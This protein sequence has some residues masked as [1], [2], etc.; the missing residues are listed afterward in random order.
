MIQAVTRNNALSQ[1]WVKCTVHTP[2]AQATH[3]PRALRPSRVHSAVSQLALGRVVART[4]AVSWSCLA[5]SQR[6][7]TMS[8]AHA[9]VSQTPDHDTNFVSQHRPLPRAAARVAAPLCLV[10]GCS[11]AVSQRCCSVSRHQMVAPSHDTNFVSQ[12]TAGKAMHACACRSPLRAGRPCSGPCWPC[13]RA[14][15]QGLLA[16]SWPPSARPS[17]LCHDTIHCIVTQTGK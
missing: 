3:R 12:L 11:Y 1:N 8:R 9:A 10:V 16:V 7:L 17:A 4:G 15:S 14:V 2:M 13:R 5:V 6:T